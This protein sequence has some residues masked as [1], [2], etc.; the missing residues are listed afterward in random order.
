[1]KNRNLELVSLW[2]SSDMFTVFG[3]PPTIFFLPRIVS[4]ARAF[5]NLP[6][7]ISADTVFSDGPENCNKVNMSNG[8]NEANEANLKNRTDRGSLIENSWPPKGGSSK[9]IH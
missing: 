5:G 2:E 9:K 8:G 7:L 4:Q 3:Y 6:R 1:M